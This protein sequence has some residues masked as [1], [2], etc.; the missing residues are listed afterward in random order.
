[1]SEQN[2]AGCAL[3]ASP[4]QNPLARSASSFVTIHG[5]DDFEP[6]SPTS[7]RVWHWASAR[8]GFDGLEWQPTC[9]EVVRSGCDEH[10]QITGIH[11]YTKIMCQAPAEADFQHYFRVSPPTVH[12]MIVT[13]EGK[14]FISRERGKART[15]CLLIP[16]DQ[17]PDLM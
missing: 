10:K 14:G 4:F 3:N 8:T 2:L 1:M 9:R 5:N 7:L 16:R 15:I 13:L 6:G 11:Y 12:Q 17:L